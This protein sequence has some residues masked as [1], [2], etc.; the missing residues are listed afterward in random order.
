MARSSPFPLL[1]I[2]FQKSNSDTLPRLQ[3]DFCLQTRIPAIDLSHVVLD[4]LKFLKKANDRVPDFCE[5][6][7]LSNADTGPT[8]ECCEVVRF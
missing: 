3:H 6:E 1:S 8:V 2:A 7:L 4:L 5:G